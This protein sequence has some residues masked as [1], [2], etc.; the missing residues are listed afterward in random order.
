MVPRVAHLDPTETAEC[1]RFGRSYL[2]HKSLRCCH[3][4][5]NARVSK[6]Q[7]SRSARNI[8]SSR[9]DSTSPSTHASH[10][11][12]AISPSCISKSPYDRSGA[13]TGATALMELLPLKPGWT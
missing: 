8:S 4:L 3:I 9:L 7:Y 5:T 2:P 12:P 1:V 10:F 13:T 6:E 11:S